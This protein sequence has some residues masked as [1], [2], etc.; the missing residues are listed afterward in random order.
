MNFEL[1]GTHLLLWQNEIALALTLR[2][3]GEQAYFTL[4]QTS[5]IAALFTRAAETR[6]PHK[7]RMPH[8]ALNLLRLSLVCGFVQNCFRFK[9]RQISTEIA[10]IARCTSCTSTAPHTE[11]RPVRHFLQLDRPLEKLCLFVKI[12][13]TWL[14]IPFAN[15]AVIYF[16]IQDLCSPLFHCSWNN[17]RLSSSYSPVKLHPF[18][19]TPKTLLQP[20]VMTYL[21]FALC[22]VTNV[23]AFSAWAFL[24]SEYLPK[25]VLLPTNARSIQKTKSQVL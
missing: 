21:S 19:D 1:S 24:F 11:A 12:T 23:D 20:F 22:L 18:S 9:C 3:W 16:R 5:S 17:E 2:H 25:P 14:P 8:S 15:Y 10:E 6:N 4:H 13:S 7:V